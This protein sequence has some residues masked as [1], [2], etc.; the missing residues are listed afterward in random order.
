MLRDDVLGSDFAGSGLK[1]LEM[2][3]KGIR[4]AAN[5]TVPRIG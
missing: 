3:A 5:E 2:E 1:K 4:K